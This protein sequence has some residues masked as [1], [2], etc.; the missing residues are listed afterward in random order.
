MSADT[1]TDTESFTPTELRMLA[2]LADG[3]PHTR[4]ELRSCLF[5]DLSELSAI[6]RHISTI[7]RKIRPIGHEII[8]EMHHRT[9]CYRHI[10]LLPSAR[11]RN[12]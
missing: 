11:H 7:R 8:C 2:L 3:L 9:I 10:C 1:L 4:E 5:D 6:K 12:A